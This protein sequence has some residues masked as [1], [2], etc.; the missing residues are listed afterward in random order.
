MWF[1]EKSDYLT[2]VQNGFISN[3]ITT[4]NLLK[5]K[6]EIQTTLQHKLN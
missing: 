6:N 2:P 3:R 5:I 4:K 1:L